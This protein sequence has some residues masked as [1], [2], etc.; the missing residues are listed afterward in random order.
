VS[1]FR[2]ARVGNDPW[3]GDT[4][5][6]ATTSPPPAYNYAVIPRVS[7]PYAMWDREDREA[8]ARALARGERTLERGHETPASTALDA[9]WDEILDMP[10]QSPWPPVLALALA[11]IFTFLLL[12]Q[13][14]AAAI[15]L[16][17]ALAVLGAWHG[18]EPQEA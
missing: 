14:I 15:S 9:D 18:R 16:V 2:G 8:D 6:W 17:V 13:W 11:A 12:R 10:A 5:E 3:E 4:L 1:R 7:S